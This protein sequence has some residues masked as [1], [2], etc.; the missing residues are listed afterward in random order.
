MFLFNFLLKFKLDSVFRKM[1]YRALCL[2]GNFE[3]FTVTPSFLKREHFRLFIAKSNWPFS[4]K[5]LVE[6]GLKT[7]IQTVKTNG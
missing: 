2:S 6:N 5:L 7:L 3:D 4:W 1:D